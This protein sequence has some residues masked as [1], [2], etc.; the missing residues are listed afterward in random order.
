MYLWTNLPPTCCACLSRTD[1]DTQFPSTYTIHWMRLPWI[2]CHRNRKTCLWPQA[3]HTS[4]ALGRQ[5]IRNWWW[6]CIKKNIW[7]GIRNILVY[8]MFPS[9]TSDV[10]AE[11]PA[12]V[13]RVNRNSPDHVRW[14]I[15]PKAECPTAFAYSSNPISRTP[16]VDVEFRKKKTIIKSIR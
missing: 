15:A 16:R 12:L 3:Q 13:R 1:C 11:P 14:P 9:L 2:E 10:S 5:T 4:G 8:I 6:K 7:I